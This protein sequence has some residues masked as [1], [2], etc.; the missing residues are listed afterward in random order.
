MHIF[1]FF[2][3]VVL[4]IDCDLRSRCATADSSRRTAGGLA[5]LVVADRF[6][7]SLGIAPHQ[8]GIHLSN[9]LGD[10]AKS[11]RLRGII[12]LV[13]PE[14]D[15]PERKNDFAGLVHRRDVVLIPPRRY[16]A[17]TQSAA[18]GYGDIIGVSSND[19]LHVRVDLA[20]IATVVHVLTGGTYTNNIIGGGHAGASIEAQGSV[21]V[22]GGVA[23]ERIK[24]DGR[25]VSA[26]GVAIEGLNTEGGVAA[27]VCIAKKRTLSERRVAV[28][29]GIAKERIKTG[30]CVEVRS[31]T[32]CE[33]TNTGC[34]VEAA[35]GIANER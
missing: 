35:G 3:F 27:A 26:V 5:D 24:T 9:L 17:P 2:S 28:T 14:A 29:G 22:A 1:M 7:L 25:V 19:G 4:R 12:F 15:R 20:N 16:V 18:A 23:K 33:C 31:R 21:E 32:T 8:I 6:G 13:V 11:Q 10:Q 30:G 34:R